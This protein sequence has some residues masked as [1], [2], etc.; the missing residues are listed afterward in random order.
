[1]GAFL[2]VVLAKLSLLLNNSKFKEEI[3]KRMMISVDLP[4]DK[5]LTAVKK[6]I[7]SNPL[8]AQAVLA[9]SLSIIPSALPNIF[10]GEE[11]P[12]VAAELQNVDFVTG[13]YN[14]AQTASLEAISGDRATGYFGQ[15]NEEVVKSADLMAASLKKTERIARLFGIRED[16]VE[17]AVMLLQSYELAD[18]QIY[19]K[20]R[21]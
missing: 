13:N 14:E 8:K 1:M 9:S 5:F 10:G 16:D 20:L 7:E 15:S 6:W 4:K 2:R 12:I 19:K 17:E 3:S 11:L 18:G 21:G